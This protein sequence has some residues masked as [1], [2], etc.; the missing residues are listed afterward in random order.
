MFYCTHLVN[1]LGSSCDEAPP[2]TRSLVLNLMKLDSRT[3]F[4]LNLLNHV[5]PFAY[6]HAHCRPGHQYLKRA[7]IT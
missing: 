3:S 1:F 6:D 4:R 7:R 5:S 2:I